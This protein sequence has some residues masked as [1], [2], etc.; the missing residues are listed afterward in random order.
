MGHLA[1]F[2]VKVYYGHALAVDASLGYQHIFAVLVFH[3]RRCIGAAVIW[4]DN[5]M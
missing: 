5:R 3:Y 4:L 2:K 1:R